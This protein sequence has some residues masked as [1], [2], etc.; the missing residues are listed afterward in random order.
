M[1]DNEYGNVL[2]GLAGAPISMRSV[3]TFLRDYDDALVISPRKLLELSEEPSGLTLVPGLRTFQEK[4]HLMGLRGYL[5]WC[6][7]ADYPGAWTPSTVREAK[8]AADSAL[9]SAREFNSSDCHMVLEMD[10]T[11]QRKLA[12]MYAAFQ[13]RSVGG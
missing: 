13:Y 2:I 6:P 1:S 10:N 5:I 8:E 3:V 9:Y 11:W 12:T 7:Y 4:N